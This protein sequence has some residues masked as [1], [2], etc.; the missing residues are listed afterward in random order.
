MSG[1][2]FAVFFRAARAH[3]KY[4]QFVVFL[5]ITVLPDKFILNSLKLRAVNLFELS[6][7]RTNQVV[8]VFVAV[9]MFK[10]FRAIPEI[11]LPANPG[12]THQLD[13]SCYRCIANP[14]VFL[15]DRVM[16]LL[17]GQVFFRS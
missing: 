2:L 4:V 14:D 12:P 17:Y 10:T 8:V 16:Q 7:F 15:P 6:T 13:R 3:A 5:N 11:D 9:L 1:L